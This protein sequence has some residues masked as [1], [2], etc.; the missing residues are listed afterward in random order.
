MEKAEFENSLSVKYWMDSLNSKAGPHSTKYIWK[1]HL[2]RF[3]EWLGKTPDQLIEERKQHL[4][5]DDE[6][7]KHE[8]EMELKRFLTSLE[9]EGL[10]PNTRGAILLL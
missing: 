4:K 8:A 2:K 1:H 3:C 5:S 7:V 6:R 9:D 10:S